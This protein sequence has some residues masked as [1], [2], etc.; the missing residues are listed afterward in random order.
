MGLVYFGQVTEFYI[1]GGVPWI[2]QLQT[3]KQAAWGGEIDVIH[4]N[5]L[6]CK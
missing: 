2:K 3:K 4:E 5:V 6:L 1:G